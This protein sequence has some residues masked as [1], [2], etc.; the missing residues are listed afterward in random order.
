VHRAPQTV[1]NFVV[2]ARYHFYDGTAIT[3][4][5]P[6]E[7]VRFGSGIEGFAADGLPGYTVP[8]ESQ[9][10][11]YAPGTLGVVPDAEGNGTA[12]LFLVTLDQGPAMP[13][14]LT[15]FGTVLDGQDAI[16]ALDGLATESGR[17]SAVL[18]ITGIDIT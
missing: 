13:P 15:T 16:T 3:Y 2:L 9:P 5:A 12:E 7:H 6:R 8:D 17:P 1:N 4:A 18:R 10:D 14:D 11:I